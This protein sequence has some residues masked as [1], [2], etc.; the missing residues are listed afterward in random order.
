LLRFN[1]LR[2]ERRPLGVTGGLQVYYQNRS[3]PILI[4]VQEKGKA[5]DVEKMRWMQL[6]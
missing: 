5:L 3:Y 4:I 6:R 2:G 1:T